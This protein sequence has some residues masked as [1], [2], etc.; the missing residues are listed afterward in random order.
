MD[1]RDS[2][3]KLNRAKLSGSDVFSDFGAAEF[4]P[5]HAKNLGFFLK[6]IYTVYCKRYGRKFE[7]PEG[8]RKGR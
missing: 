8:R 3:G 7:C 6:K 4:F 2:P 5:T 1:A